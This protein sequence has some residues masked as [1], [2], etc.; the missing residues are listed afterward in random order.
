MCNW[1][2]LL[3]F[4]LMV[5]VVG[6]GVWQD[7]GMGVILNY[8]GVFVLFLLLLVCQLVFGVMMLVV[9]CYELNGL[10]FVGLWVWLCFQFCC[11][12]FDGQSGMIYGFVYVFVVE[13]FCFV[14][15]VFGGG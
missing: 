10:I 6:E 11:V 4:F 3:F 15:E 7:S 8:W 5:Q 2:V 9:W 12:E 13:L 14:W 1:L